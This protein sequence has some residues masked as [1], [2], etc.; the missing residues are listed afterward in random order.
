M[1]LLDF[2]KWLQNSAQTAAIAENAPVMTAAGWRID[3][4]GRAVQDRQN[5]ANVQQLRENLSALGES[6]VTAPGAAEAIEGAYTLLRHPVRTSRFIK[7]L[8]SGGNEYAINQEKA[9]II[10]KEIDRQIDNNPILSVY[11]SNPRLMDTGSAYEYSDYIQSIFPESIVNGTYYHGGPQGITEFK[12]PNQLEHLNQGINTATKDHGI[13]FTPDKYLARIYATTATKKAGQPNIYTT[14]L[15]I[16]NPFRYEHPSWYAEKFLGTQD[17]RFSPGSIS[18]KWYD[19]LNLKNYDSVLRTKS[20]NAWDDG[21]IAMLN[22]EDIHILGSQ[23][24]V[25]GF[26]QWKQNPTYVYKPLDNLEKI[27]NNPVAYMK[28]FS[29]YAKAAA[30]ALKLGSMVAIPSISAYYASKESKG[31]RMRRRRTPV[32]G[33]QL[34]E[35]TV[36]PKKKK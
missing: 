16:R 22:P 13:Y 10:A 12:T 2:W 32:D 15:N 21:E 29:N 4:N 24:D 35:I 34:P 17:L 33:G 28:S 14:R 30:P 18:Q 27:E 3:E 1:G 7:N 5:D 19:K 6:A 9:R 36:Y 23:K 31:Q 11:Q 8:I 20:A 26:T 25:N